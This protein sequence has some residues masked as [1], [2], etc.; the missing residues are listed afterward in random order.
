[1]FQNRSNTLKIL[2]NLCI[3]LRL[4]VPIKGKNIKK[5]YLLSLNPEILLRVTLKEIMRIIY[6]VRTQN[7]SK[8]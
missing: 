1:M 7:F 5:N 4:M 2:L 3:S 8:D 6:L